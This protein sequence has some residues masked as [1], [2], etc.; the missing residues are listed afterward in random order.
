MPDDCLHRIEAKKQY[1]V[2]RSDSPLTEY[3]GP[4]TLNEAQEWIKFWEA[5]GGDDDDEPG[6][7][8]LIAER[9][10]TDWRVTE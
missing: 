5:R 6:V 2:V 10:V 1:A 4:T 8:M 9:L 3:V 7:R